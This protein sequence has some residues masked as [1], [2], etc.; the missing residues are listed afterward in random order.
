M[1]TIHAVCYAIKQANYG[2]AA[3]EVGE[4]VSYK[5]KNGVVID[6]DC[7]EEEAWKLGIP[8]KIIKAIKGALK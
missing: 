6:P 2:K 8:P 3:P 4:V 5:P 1:K 7:F